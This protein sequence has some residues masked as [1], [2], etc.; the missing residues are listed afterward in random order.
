MMM[1]PALDLLRA[2]LATQDGVHDVE[3]A[4]CS[5]LGA[6]EALVTE[7]DGGE[8]VSQS[9]KVAGFHLCRRLH[10]FNV[11]QAATHT[12]VNPHSGDSWACDLSPLTCDTWPAPP[13]SP[14]G[15]VSDGNG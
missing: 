11:L 6:L 8:L 15:W 14:G 1:T 7:E 5:Q 3:A 2:Y 10:Q 12:Q 4:S 13:L 9:V